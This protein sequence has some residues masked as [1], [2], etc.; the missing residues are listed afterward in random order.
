MLRLVRCNS[1]KSALAERFQQILDEKL[2]LASRSAI[3]KDEHL[4]LQLDC[5]E[6]F[7]TERSQSQ[8]EGAA[9][10]QKYQR[11]IAFVNSEKRFNLQNERNDALQRP[12]NGSELVLETSRRMLDDSVA[13][14]KRVERKPSRT[15]ISPPVPLSERIQNAKELSLDYKVGKAMTPE[16]KEREQFKEMYK[17]RLLGPSVFLNSASSSSTMGLI[18]SMA[19][20]R[21]NAEI[22]QKTGTFSSQEMLSVRGKPLDKDR[23]KNSTDT[24]YFMNELLKKQDCLPT[25]IENQQGVDVEVNAFR[26]NLKSQ[27]V[28]SLHKLAKSGDGTQSVAE[29]KLALSV[30]TQDK[31]ESK[32]LLMILKTKK[33]YF[34][35]KIAD[36]NTKIRHYNLSAPSSSLHK[37][38]LIEENEYQTAISKVVLNIDE[39]L[40]L[41]NSQHTKVKEKQVSSSFLGLLGEKGPSINT[42][43]SGIERPKESLQFWQLVKDIFKS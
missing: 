16:E 24:A 8:L 25:W 41:A 3:S 38:K 22:D 14:A 29:M 28:S 33:D 43:Y 9:F 11:E 31:L 15:I 12:W 5:L 20:A 1:T 23:L 13:K 18:T 26:A 34:Q 32:L 4:S 19:D 37:W 40:E 27:A 42:S 7:N 17:E 10:E 21:I 39:A 6:Q 30:Y 2:H 36:I 35:S